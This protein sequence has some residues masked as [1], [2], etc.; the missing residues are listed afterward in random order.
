MRPRGVLSMLRPPC[1]K[2]SSWGS[3]PTL[4]S[5]AGRPEDDLPTLSGIVCAPAAKERASTVTIPVMERVQFIILFLLFGRGR[6]R[7]R[8][9]FLGDN[10]HG[11]FHRNLGDAAILID[12]ACFLVGFRIFP[13]FLAQIVL[14][15]GAVAGNAL[16]TTLRRHGDEILHFLT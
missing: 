16:P 15:I 3:K 7:S 5:C 14:R 12:P 1:G 11:V 13:D 9:T 8:Q 2:G 10:L 4:W 6:G